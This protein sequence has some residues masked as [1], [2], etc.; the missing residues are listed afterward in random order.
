MI[1]FPKRHCWKQKAGRRLNVMLNVGHWQKVQAPFIDL[2]SGTE[3]V[4]VLSADHVQIKL[5]YAL[6]PT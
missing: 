4:S 1:T 2:S 3:R 6:H 5:P